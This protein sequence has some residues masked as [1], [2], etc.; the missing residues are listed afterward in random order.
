M[1][2]GLVRVISDYLIDKNRPD[3]VPDWLTPAVMER[4]SQRLRSRSL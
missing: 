4:V 3:T 2:E 1:Y